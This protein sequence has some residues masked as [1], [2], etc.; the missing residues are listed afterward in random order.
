MFDIIKLWKEDRPISC[1]REMENV[2]SFCVFVS[3]LDYIENNLCSPIT[4][5]EIAKN[6]YCS[7]SA[8]QKI[9]R[10]CTHT[11]LKE[12]ISKRRLT[13]CAEELLK[14]DATITDIAFRY[15]YNS[16]EVFCR[17]FKKLWNVSPSE[18]RS[19]WRFT[20][21]F[22]KIT[23][24]E[25]NI[26]GNYMGRKVDISELY[27]LLRSMAV[28]YVLCFDIVGLDMINKNYGYAV[29]DAVI[30][31]T[32]RRIDSAAGE[33]CTVFRIGGDEFCMVTG[34]TDKFALEK[35][36]DAVLSHNGEEITSEGVTLPVAVRAAAVKYSAEHF[37]YKGLFDRLW[38]VTNSLDA[39]V[40]SAIQYFDFK[41]SYRQE[42]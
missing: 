26:G 38:E 7:L 9:W 12:Y 28:T 6:C 20:G 1:L 2:R 33:E 19:T 10:Y 21:I 27:E 36:A 13:R 39:D 5:E 4:Q 14:T 3:A 23:A 8:L 37:N 17:A 40:T 24:D 18:F 31:E 22:P 25:N 34:L 30:L 15:Q 41:I 16:S 42:N 35:L 29:G 11:S 32:A